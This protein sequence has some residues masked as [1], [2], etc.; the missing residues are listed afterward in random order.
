MYQNLCYWIAITVQYTSA[1]PFKVSFT[2]VVHLYFDICLKMCGIMGDV[3][4]AVSFSIFSGM[5]DGPGVFLEFRATSC[6]TMPLSP[7]SR[8]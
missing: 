8:V 2:Q 6:F 5:S 7:I 3:S 1:S 4:L